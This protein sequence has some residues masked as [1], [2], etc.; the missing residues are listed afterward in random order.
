M[1]LVP[2]IIQARVR[3]EGTYV[4]MEI[5]GKIITLSHEQALQLSGVIR[6]QAKKAGEQARAEAIAMDQAI[7]L[8]SGF[9]LGLSSHPLIKKEAVKEACWNS[10]LRRYIRR[11]KMGNIKSVE[12]VGEPSII[13]G[14]PPIKN[15]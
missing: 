2:K 7:L 5:G 8:R 12:A 11:S 10:N 15:E 6:H 13:L 1:I 9:P 3:R 14:P 4:V